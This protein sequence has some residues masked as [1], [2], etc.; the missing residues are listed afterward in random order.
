M[1]LA[2]MAF[3]FGWLVM[4]WLTWRWRR[5]LITPAEW[6]KLVDHDQDLRA[7]EADNANL[8]ARIVGLLCDLDTARADLVTTTHDAAPDRGRAV[9]P[10]P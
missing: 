7:L 9:H 3:L 8:R 10:C 6:A 4:G 2:L 1:A 5:L